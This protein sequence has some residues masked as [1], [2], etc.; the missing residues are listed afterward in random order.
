MRTLLTTSALI[1]VAGAAAA[2]VNFSGYGRFGL[3]YNE[4]N[5]DAGGE[6]TALISRFRLNIDADAYTDGGVQ[7]SA[8]VRLQA[9][10]DPEINE[11]NS[12]TLNGARFSAIYQG[13]RL[14]VG[15]VSGAFDASDAYFGFEPGLEAFTGQYAAVDYDFLEYSSTGS[16]ANAVA[17]F[18]TGPNFL[19]GGSYD[20]DEVTGNDRWDISA[21]YTFADAYTLYV[22]YGEN[23]NDQ[24]L[25]IG[26]LTA[27][28]DRFTVNAFLGDEDL[29]LAPGAEDTDGT[30]YGLSAG[31]DVGT[32]TQ[33]V[34]S[35]GS[36][37]GDADTEAYA[38][39][40]V[41]DLGGGV[42]LKGGI[43]SEGPRNGSSS[44]VGDLGVL[45]NF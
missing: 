7:F 34:A 23:D 21:Q 11:Q 17:A 30:V 15:N 6:D 31:F 35:Y 29:N 25:L 18:Y 2:Q 33:I 40:F 43:G 45:F 37:S 32:A 24:S 39:G 26:V 27:D 41:H 16:G 9:D 8:R 14:D 20:P 44:T 19:V 38:V 28:F 42:A 36:G 12:A 13:F 22:G 4:A 5:G 10:D 1:L 3:G